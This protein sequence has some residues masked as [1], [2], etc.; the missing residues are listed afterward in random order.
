MLQTYNYIILTRKTWHVF[1]NIVDKFYKFLL[2]EL[3]INNII[4]YYLGL[5]IF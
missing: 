1:W 3:T 5:M 4:K 2:Q